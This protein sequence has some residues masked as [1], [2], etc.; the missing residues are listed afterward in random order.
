MGMAVGVDYSLFYL[1]RERE[2]RAAG[3]EGH[4][5]L[6]RAAAT[7]GQAVLISGLTVLIAM[8]GLLFAGSKIFTSIGIG[9]MLVVFTALPGSPAPAR[10]VVNGADVTSPAFAQAFADMKRRAL[11]T[12]QIHQP[13]QVRVNPD[14]TIARIDMPLAGNGEDATAYRALN[15]LRGTVIPPFVAALPEGSQ[16]LVTGDTAG[17]Y[18]FNQ[19]MKHR[20]WRVFAFVL[21]LAFL[22]L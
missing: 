15:T 13:I 6:F 3:H 2:E 17:S 10:V 4:E 18:D 21:G 20:I 9:A 1:K 5:G 7:S 16:A 12:G 8:A 11:A 14:R 19:T 22:L